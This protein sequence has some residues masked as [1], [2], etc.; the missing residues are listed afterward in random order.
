MSAKKFSLYRLFLYTALSA[1]ALSV[2]FPVLWVLFASL[3]TPGEFY[4][5]PFSLPTTFHFQNFTDAWERAD[6]GAYFLNSVTVTALALLILLLVAL[7]ASYVLAR[8]RFRFR[9]F[10]KTLFMAGLFINVSYLVVPIFLMLVDI[11]S[12]IGS[13]I[14]LNNH[15]VLA[16]V[17]AATAL[18]FTVYLL[19]GFFADLPRELEEAAYVDGAGSFRTMVTIMT[20]LARPAVITVILFNFLAFWN[21]YIIAIT[22][23]TDDRAKTLPVGLF[24]LMKAQNAGAQY[25]QLYAGLVIVMLP[26]LILYIL[27]Q[28]KI[29]EGLSLGGVKG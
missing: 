26:T 9:T 14:L 28:K 23:M 1:L 22:L 3:K 20:P 7:P 18:P 21:E 12:L 6:M 15:A 29:T 2:L 11:N 4:G 16:T 10:F 24:N 27:L 13:P 8:F 5:H 25:G 19:S 17:Y